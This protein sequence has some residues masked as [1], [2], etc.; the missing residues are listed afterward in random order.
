MLVNELPG[1]RDMAVPSKLTSYFSSGVPVLAATDIG[2][3]TAAEI[4]ASGGGIRVDAG[5]PRALFD[6]AQALANDKAKSLALAQSGLQFRHDVL[7][8]TAAIDRYDDFVN[9]MIAARSRQGQRH[10]P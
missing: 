10:S 3:V 7:S 9:G 2:S 8:S 6:A 5:D 4:S 1:V